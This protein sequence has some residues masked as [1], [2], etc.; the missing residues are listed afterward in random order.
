M[1]RKVTEFKGGNSESISAPEILDHISGRKISDWTGD[2]GEVDDN[3]EEF[4][5][6]HPH[7]GVAQSH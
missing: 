6:S 7:G 1:R 3:I 5:S 2:L 4:A